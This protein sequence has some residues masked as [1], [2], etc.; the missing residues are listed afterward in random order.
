MSI[1]DDPDPLIHQLILH[2]GFR[3]RA[4]TDTVGKI[5]IGIGRN[6]TDVGISEAEAR[7]FLLNDIAKVKEQLDIELPWWRGQNEARQRAMID[8]C[9]NM[10]I[11]ALL[12]FHNG[13]SAWAN[14]NYSEAARSF[15]ASQWAHQVQAARVNRV[16]GQ[17]ET[18]VA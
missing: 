17:V 11:G 6:L 18:G 15:R 4:Y 5:T 14:G 10:G 9:F 8:L 16:T 3:L 12:G 7:L 2:E 13:L 1:L